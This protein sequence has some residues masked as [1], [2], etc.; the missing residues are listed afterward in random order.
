MEG[1]EFSFLFAKAIETFTPLYG[2]YLNITGT[3]QARNL[4]LACVLES[5]A[6]LFI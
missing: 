2:K 3:K 6:W 4:K 5:G 1:K